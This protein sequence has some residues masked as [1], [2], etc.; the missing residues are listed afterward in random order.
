MIPKKIHYCWFGGKPLPKL[1]KK[2][3]SSWKKFLPDYE[4][5]EWNEQNFNINCCDY[6]K[7]A[8]QT[9]KYAFVSDYV[10]LYVLV[11]YGGVYMDTDVEV[12]KPINEFLQLKA[13]SGF[14]GAESIPTGIMACEKGHELFKEFLNE[15]NNIHFILKDNEYD[16]TTNVARITNT[17]KKYGLV[18]NNKHQTIKDFTL[19]PFDYFCPQRSDNSFKGRIITK[20]TYTI[21]HFE[22][23]WLPYHK[24]IYRK[25]LILF[26]SNYKYVQKIKNIFIKNKK[27]F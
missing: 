2:C 12:M 22:G 5:I 11:K 14:Q 3:I 10:R 16:L 27:E 6:V 4:I 9:K 21:H 20:N 8:Y 1:A 7:E 15:Y 18:V 17:C 13:F 24:R 26:G 25:I 19:F 23:S